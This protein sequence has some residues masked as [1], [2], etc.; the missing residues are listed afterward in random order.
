MPRRVLPLVALLALGLVGSPVRADVIREG[1]GPQR[2]ALDKMELQPFPS[3]AW[4]KLSNWTNGDAITPARIDGK[5]VLI[6]TWAAWHPSARRAVQLAQ[7]MADKYG[8][9]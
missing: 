8:G 2:A 6:F 1:S 4:S 9:Q 3:D 5:P 7:K